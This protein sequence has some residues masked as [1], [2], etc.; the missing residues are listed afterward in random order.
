[1]A[2][3]DNSPTILERVREMSRQALERDAERLIALNL[4]KDRISEAA[5]EGFFRL[6][7]SPEKPLDIS[8]TAVAKITTEALRKEG[9]IVEW[10]VRQH[11]NGQSS[12]TLTVSWKP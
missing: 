2:S 8:Q 5:S 3:P 9:F 4:V 11:P 10:D 12:Q 1:M 6:S 7:I